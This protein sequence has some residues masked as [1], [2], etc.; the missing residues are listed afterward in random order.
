MKPLVASL[1]LCIVILF[2]GGCLEGGNLSMGKTTPE[3]KLNKVILGFSRRE[4]ITDL[5]SLRSFQR[6]LDVALK[7]APLKL[8]PE[9]NHFKT[10]S[11]FWEAWLLSN[12]KHQADGILENLKKAKKSFE[13]AISD[14]QSRELYLLGALMYSE[15]IRF[16]KIEREKYY[17]YSKC[18]FYLANNSPDESESLKRF[19]FGQHYF[20]TD[21][22]EV[23]STY[24]DFYSGHYSRALKRLESMD[25]DHY[26]PEYIMAHSYFCLMLGDYD[27]AVKYME[28]FKS[29]RY[30]SFY[31][32]RAAL[33]QLRLC[34]EALNMRNPGDY[35]IDIKVVSNLLK[36]EQDFFTS[37]NLLEFSKDI[38]ISDEKKALGD[39]FD[40]KTNDTKKKKILNDLLDKEKW[41]NNFLKID[42][43]EQPDVY[44]ECLY[45]SARL[46]DRSS[47][48]E[49]EK[50]FPLDV[51]SLNADI[52]DKPDDF[53]Y[54]IGYFKE[55]EKDKIPSFYVFAAMGSDL[56]S[57][58][59]LE[60]SGN[61]Y[62][63]EPDKKMGYFKLS[64]FRVPKKDEKAILSVFIKK[65][66][67]KI[68]F[69]IPGQNHKKKK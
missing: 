25:I 20:S 62:W 66:E 69:N 33:N 2:L 16:D 55:R 60:I 57:E 24:A 29:P 7:G 10:W 26:S 41:P 56:P 1:L 40:I 23:L 39:V 31:L 53:H 12:R 14:H 42:V 6:D 15:F 38:Y 49:I 21:E 37:K 65:K 58:I 5:G 35:S 50:K 18:C 4:A 9:I 22:I 47:E 17:F 32:Y 54:F 48:I 52:E 3:Q 51:Y 43:I 61:T 63:L 19:N 30:R 28:I 46:G 68:S 59:K 45:Q 8:V 13:R 34:Y 67:I 36:E 44:R 11:L 64:S 27:D